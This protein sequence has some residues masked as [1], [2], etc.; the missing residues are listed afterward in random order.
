MTDRWGR[1]GDD[2]DELHGARIDDGDG[3]AGAGGVSEEAGRASLKSL[4]FPYPH[5]KFSSP[6]AK[7]KSKHF[8]TLTHLNFLSFKPLFLVC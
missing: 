1:E 2:G 3:D 7:P 6:E 5:S 8:K 4:F